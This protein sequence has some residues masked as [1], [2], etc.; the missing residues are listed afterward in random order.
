MV[1]VPNGGAK[2]RK[3]TG[4]CKSPTG[5]GGILNRQVANSQHRTSRSDGCRPL[6][7]FASIILCP[8]VCP[9]ELALRAC[10][11]VLQPKRRTQVTPAAP[12]TDYQT[13]AAPGG[14]TNARTSG[15]TKCR[16]NPSANVSRQKLETYKP[17]VKI[18]RPLRKI[19]RPLVNVSR[20]DNILAFF[21]AARRLRRFACKECVSLRRRAPWCHLWC[22]YR[23]D[24]PMKK[25]Y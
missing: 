21:L 7:P 20:P 17:L 2:I 18:S 25:P 24:L 16:T 22:D 13:V 8:A 6:T 10:M 4:R 19:S 1:G 23:C 15:R 3:K 12:P 11:R 9:Q 14:R 5:V